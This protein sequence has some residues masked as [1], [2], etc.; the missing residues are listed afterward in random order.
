MSIN[1]K[2]GLCGCLYFIVSAIVSVFICVYNEYTGFQAIGIF[3]CALIVFA[4]V[5]QIIYDLF[6][7]K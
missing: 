7:D 6:I 5:F 1:E 4:F 3:F 2:A